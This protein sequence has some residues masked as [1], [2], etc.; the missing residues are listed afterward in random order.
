MTAG[1]WIILASFLTYGIFHS[2]LASLRVKAQARR[3]FGPSTDRW[4]RIAYNSIAILSLLP[5][6]TLPI[7]FVDKELYRIPYPWNLLTAGI[8][9]L[10]FVALF[11]GLRQTGLLSFLGIRQLMS[12]SHGTPPKFVTGGLYRWVRHP[13]YTAGLMII[14][15]FPIMTC[16]LLALNIS[17]TIYIL[18][19]AII[20]ERKLEREFGEAY[21]EYKRRTPMFIPLLHIPSSRNI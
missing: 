11:I 1:F 7:L 4:F 21:V 13:L 5:I 19:G 9:M 3:I 18:L 16:N 2:W 14:W 20:E 17:M 6:L 12:S 8:Q 10:A 15:L